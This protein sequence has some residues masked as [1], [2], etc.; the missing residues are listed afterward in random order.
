MMLLQLLT[1]PKTCKPCLTA[2]PLHVLLSGLRPTTRRLWW[3]TKLWQT[4]R[5]LE[6]LRSRWMARSWPLWS[7]SAS[8]VLLPQRS[9]VTRNVEM[10]AELNRHIGCVASCL[11]KLQKWVWVNQKLRLETKIVMHVYC[12]PCCVDLRHAW[13]IYKKQQPSSQRLSSSRPPGA[14]EGAPG[15][16]E[17]ERRW[18]LGW[19]SRSSDL[20]HS[21]WETWG[22]SWGSAGD[23]VSNA[24][25]LWWWGCNSM[26]PISHYQVAQVTGLDMYADCR[27]TGYPRWPSSVS[28]Y[29]GFIVEV[30]QFY[31]FKIKVG[32]PAALQYFSEWGGVGMCAEKLVAEACP[33]WCHE[34]SSSQDSGRKSNYARNRQSR[35]R[36]LDTLGLDRP[37]YLVF[38]SIS[39]TINKYSVHF[40]AKISGQL[41]T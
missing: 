41:K 11:R 6:S 14:R 20:T 40:H 3:Y 9:Y 19:R 27:M 24:E 15:G 1:H 12:Q 38:S 8:S 35:C 21:I 22:E 36:R 32:W 13:S 31:I 18:E 29:L 5:Q 39:A 7:S 34:S 2:L 37:I 10:E 23:R 4:N 26:H 25:V 17:E 28:W 30:G 33:Q 16:R